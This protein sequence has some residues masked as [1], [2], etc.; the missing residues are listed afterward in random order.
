[1]ALWFNCSIEWLD[2]APSDEQASLMFKH[3]YELDYDFPKELFTKKEVLYR[4]PL[5]EWKQISQ[6]I[7]D[8]GFP[9]VLRYWTEDYDGLRNEDRVIAAHR[10]I[11]NA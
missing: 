8:Q 1:M 7:L 3:F 9:H 10:K 11:I 2:T 6:Y 4:E 5:I